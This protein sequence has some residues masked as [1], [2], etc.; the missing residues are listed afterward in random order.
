MLP[1]TQEV[2]ILATTERVWSLCAVRGQQM[3]DP[4]RRQELAVLLERR[5]RALGDRPDVSERT[6]RLSQSSGRHPLGSRPPVKRSTTLT[7][8]FGA[9]AVVAMLA[10]VASA[11]MVTAGGLW[12]Q[13]QLNDPANTVQKFYSALHEQDYPDAYALLSASTRSHLSQSAFADQY[14]SYDQVSGIVE[15]Y[16]IVKSAV[17][18]SAASFTVA[19]VRRGNTSM[20]QLETL[21]LVSENG[22][23]VISGITAGGIVPAPTA[24]T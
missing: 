15:S 20:A 18:G 2:T 24:T 6:R 17:N 8:L 19:V 12:F 3:N 13:S 7:L 22:N 14:S 11:V 1:C 9:L 5:R 21:Q 23:W 4:K 16:P 10:C